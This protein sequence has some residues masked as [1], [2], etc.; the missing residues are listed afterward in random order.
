MPREQL[1]ARRLGGSG[2]REARARV[3]FDAA[4]RAS[5]ERA[6][7]AARVHGHV[8]PRDCA[9]LRQGRAAL[10]R[11]AA[12]GAVPLR[13][14]LWTRPDLWHRACSVRRLWRLLRQHRRV[15]APRAVG[16]AETARRRVQQPLEPGLLRRADVPTLGQPRSHTAPV[17]TAL[18]PAGAQ[19]AAYSGQQDPFRQ[20]YGD[21]R[22]AAATAFHGPFGP[23]EHAR[24]GGEEVPRYA[25]V[26]PRAEPGADAPLGWALSSSS[27]DALVHQLAGKNT[28]VLEDVRKMALQRPHLCLSQRKRRACADTAR[29]S[30][31]AGEITQRAFNVVGVVL[32]LSG[33]CPLRASPGLPPRRPRRR[34]DTDELGPL[35]R[36]AEEYIRTKHRSDA[37]VRA[38][39]CTCEWAFP[40]RIAQCRS[41]GLRLSKAARRG[42]IARESG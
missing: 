13:L 17:G 19:R 8:R 7:R 21:F 42:A 1:R 2:G 37:S 31:S 22:Q 27:T 16:D 32:G 3:R 10:Y 28:D 14:A 6:A 23:F 36:S 4:V 20:H 34:V 35:F 40:R 15:R 29:M 11:G 30:P 25:Y 41:P 5:A 26:Y 18:A 9:L 39:A 24:E 33:S 38:V 12:V